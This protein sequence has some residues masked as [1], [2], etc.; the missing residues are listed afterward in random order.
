MKQMVEFWSS[1][2]ARTQ[3]TLDVYC[4]VTIVT[5]YCYLFLQN[6]FLFSTILKFLSLLSTLNL[7]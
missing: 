5:I 3:V 1:F 7:K 4:I 6:L 2:F